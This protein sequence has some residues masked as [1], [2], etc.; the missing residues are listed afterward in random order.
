MSCRWWS[1][2]NSAI[3]QRLTNEDAMLSLDELGLWVVADGMG[4]HLRGDLA[5]R[6][7]VEA[8][9]G[10]EKPDS[11]DAF[12]REVSTRLYLANER[13]H[14][15][16]ATLSDTEIIGSTVVAVMVQD[17]KFV[18]LWAG[19]SRAYLLSR[20]RLTQLTHDHTAAQTFVDTGNLESTQ[21][22]HHP[23]AHMLTR[24]VG[25][26]EMLELEEHRGQIRD[27]DALLLC[28]D[29]L[30]KEVDDDELAPILEDF[31]CEEA[32]QELV[33][34]SLERGASDN[35]TVTVIRFEATT[36]VPREAFDQTAINFDFRLRS[37]RETA[38][39]MRL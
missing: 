27:G 12:A 23:A 4:G 9:E 21:A 2:T 31:D 38:R 26:Q 8:F 3:G 10:I 15:Y 16:A 19:D 36:G 20:D 13:I 18:C 29:G 7:V 28:S 25:A 1:S 34:L 6:F 32:C 17:N 5:S 11:I 37:G 35:V 30:I 39:V 33:D 24:A 14:K 22:K